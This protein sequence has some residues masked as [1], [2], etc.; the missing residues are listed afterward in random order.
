MRKPVQCKGLSSDSQDNSR[1]P[2]LRVL[3][4]YVRRVDSSEDEDESFVLNVRKFAQ[5]PE[6]TRLFHFTACNKWEHSR[7]S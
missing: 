2:K 1:K 7:F 5:Y 6:P 3:K 4:K